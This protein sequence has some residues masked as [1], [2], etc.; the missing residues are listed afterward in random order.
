MRCVSPHQPNVHEIRNNLAEYQAEHLA[1]A[2]RGEE[3]LVCRRNQPVARQVAVQP[4]P[5]REARPLG[6]A[7]DAGTALPDRFFEP[8]PD[9][10][11]M[12]LLTPDPAIQRYPVPVAW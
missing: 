12:T 4:A 1:A 6:L 5:R 10:L 7:A 11:L 9:Q 2:E 3:V 8:L